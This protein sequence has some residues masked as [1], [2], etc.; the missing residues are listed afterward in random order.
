MSDT[1]ITSGRELT[2]ENV[3]YYSTLT[4]YAID[5]IATKCE[6]IRYSNNPKDPEYYR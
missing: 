6:N 5:L 4:A 2:S 3:C 1:P